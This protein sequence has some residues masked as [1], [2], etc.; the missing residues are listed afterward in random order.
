ME[1]SK[2]APK[3]LL[4]QEIDVR[5]QPSDGDK[6]QKATRQHPYWGRIPTISGRS[7]LGISQSAI[8]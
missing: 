7:S 5:P 2:D 3:H 6:Q 8:G 1:I 4:V